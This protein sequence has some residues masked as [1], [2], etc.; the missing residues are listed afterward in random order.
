MDLLREGG[1]GRDNRLIYGPLLNPLLSAFCNFN[2]NQGETATVESNLDL[3][4]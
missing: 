2:H 3:Q 1:G 4:S